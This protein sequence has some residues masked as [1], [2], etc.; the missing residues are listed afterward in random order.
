MTNQVT[1]LVYNNK[2]SLISDQ[3]QSEIQKADVVLVYDSKTTQDLLKKYQELTKGIISPSNIESTH[4]SEFLNYFYKLK[5]IVIPFNPPLDQIS[6][7][8]YR[9][10]IKTNLEQEQKL[11]SEFINNQPYQALNTSEFSISMYNQ[12]FT[13]LFNYLEN[14]LE[15]IP[16]IIQKTNQNLA[17][18]QKNILIISNPNLLEFKFLKPN[19]IDQT[20]L[21]EN[22]FNLSI[23]H[24][25]F[26]RKVLDLEITESLI[27]GYILECTLKNLAQEKKLSYCR[28]CQYPHRQIMTNL[29]FEQFLELSELSSQNNTPD[30]LTES[31]NSYLDGLAKIQEAEYN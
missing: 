26:R 9:N 6:H 3:T 22:S 31:I 19:L 5:K 28:T 7:N 23:R 20:I 13:Y 11:T 14:Y 18:L 21:T 29:K 1:N 15:D 8:P 2:D 10:L 16:S 25:I 24:E 30:R 12:T 4:S 17:Y 27:Y